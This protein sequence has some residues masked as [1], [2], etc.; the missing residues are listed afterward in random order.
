MKK[1]IL[2][3]IVM[4]FLAFSLV[5]TGCKDRGLKN[6][7]ATD[8]L[9]ISNGGTTVVKG[10]YLYFVNGYVDETS[11]TKDDNKQGKVTRGAIYRTKL[12]NSEI[13]KD[14]DGFLVSDRTDLVVSRVVGFSNGG[15]FI[16]DDTIY[17]ATPY[18]MLDKDGTLLSDR[19]EIRSIN[20]NGDT[21]TD[22][23]VYV[24]D[25]H[26][27]NLDWTM[28]KVDGQVY[29]VLYCNSVI[30]SVKA[31]NG[32]VVAKIEKSSTYAFYHEDNY[33]TS[34]DRS[35]NK[36]RYVYYTRAVVESDRVSANF[37]GNVICAF[38]VTNG[39]VTEALNIVN[40][41]TIAITKVVDNYLY[42]TRTT[43]GSQ[44]YLYRQDTRQAWNNNAEDMT[45][46][47]AYATYYPC[48]FG[49]YVIAT[50]DN[51]T[52]LVSHGNAPVKISTDSISVFNVYGGYAY[53]LSSEVLYRFKVTNPTEQETVAAEGKTLKATSANLIDFDNQR[54]YVFAEY[55]G[56]YYLDYV[57]DTRDTQRFV[58]VF[59]DGETPE[60][61]EQTEGY[62]ED[63]DIEYIPHID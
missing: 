41:D 12:D 61:P 48:A 33:S 5:L 43:A 22:K 30:Y 50:N 15:F 27:D 14:N 16:I 8:A 53:Y 9:T 56:N 25:T 3:V 52:W 13:V 26:M 19:V 39:N 37:S 20:I 55:D 4:F 24:T 23:Q 46:G 10:D 2:S 34:K 40:N 42:Y 38:D 29:L 47:V 51:G 35:G 11:L 59:A 21:K 57:D 44:I 45:N 63:P 6:N 49:D 18:M 32:E 60:A 58:G 1:K 36:Y 28:Y 62:G 31:S 54:L 7:P 17:Y